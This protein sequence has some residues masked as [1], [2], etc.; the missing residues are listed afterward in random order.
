MPTIVLLRHGQAS[1]GSADYDV[2]SP[3]GERQ[4]ALAGS[5]LRRRGLRTP[6]LV[7]GTLA[8]QV[9]TARIAGTVMGTDLQASDP[10]WNELDAHALVDAR[11]GTPGASL[12]MTSAA[13][14]EVL[15]EALVQWMSVPGQGWHAFADGA[16]SALQEL[17][18][19]LPRGCDAVV[20]TSAGVIG[21]LAARVIGAKPEVAVQFNRV[22]V[23][24]SLTVVAAS[25]RRLS[26]VTFNDH[27]H[28]LGEPGLVT[29]R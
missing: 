8:R 14:Q 17:A 15:D 11:L 4:A 27:A 2:L 9:D 18:D 1:F 19:G 13:F 21:A 28:L 10:R 6:V 26:L 24:A 20:T 23:N 12:D 29:F 25:P 16:C 22:M 3:L 7:S 5:E